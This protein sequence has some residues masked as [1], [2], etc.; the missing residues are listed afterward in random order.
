MLWSKTVIYKSL[1]LQFVPQEVQ[2][3]YQVLKKCAGE[4]SGRSF[5]QFV[6]LSFLGS[7]LRVLV[8]DAMV[9]MVSLIE[10]RRKLL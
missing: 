6:L 4:G 1:S 5:E 9:E 8:A 10:M 3:Q 7:R 2:D